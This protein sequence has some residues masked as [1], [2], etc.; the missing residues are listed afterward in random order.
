M[1]VYLVRDTDA[2]K[3]VLVFDAG[4]SSMT[5]AIARAGAQLG[6]ITRVVLGHGHQDHRGAAPG[7]RVPV[8]CHAADVDIAQGDG[9]FASFDFSLLKPPTRWLMPRMLKVW[10]GGPVDIAGTVAEDDEVAGFRVVH[11]PG[12][13]A[14]LIALYRES[15]GLALTSDVF[16]TL[17]PETTLHGHPRVPHRAFNLDT[18]QARA[19]IRK[20]AALEPKAAWPGH[21]DPLTGDV[22]AQ[23]E[24]AAATT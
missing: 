2:P 10:D 17:D 7:L 16:Y 6:G 12:H 4:I 22:R 18:E 19:S 20:L 5:A 11:C 24:Q 15:D 21:A 8:H 14:G 9:G 23:L 1:N 3:G 13:A